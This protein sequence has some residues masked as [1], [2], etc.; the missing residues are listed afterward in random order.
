MYGYDILVDNNCKPWLVEVNASP[1]LTTTSKADKEIKTKLL[2]D[3]MTIVS[4]A[5]WTEYVNMANAALTSY[6][7]DEINRDSI[8]RDNIKKVGNFDL[9]VDES[10]QDSTKRYL[11][12]MSSNKT[13][14]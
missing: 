13:W 3:V 4:P 11:R 14:K 1:S 12:K 9:L 5:E 10:Q 6:T 7:S 2:D 8:L